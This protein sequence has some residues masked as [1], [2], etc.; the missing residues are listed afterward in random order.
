MKG[1]RQ[2]NRIHPYL[3][4]AQIEEMRAIGRNPPRGTWAAFIRKHGL[5]V[6]VV[7]YMKERMG[8]VSERTRSK[9]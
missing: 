2:K 9:Q 6:G 3:T 7:Q 5:E 4:E 1:Q 8:L